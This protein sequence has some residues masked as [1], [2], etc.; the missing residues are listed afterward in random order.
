M[1][2]KVLL[3]EDA[4]SLCRILKKYLLQ[5]GFAVITADN[6]SEA[7]I[8]AKQAKPD[9][10]ISDA[11]IPYLDGPGLCHILKKDKET[12]HIP[13]IIIS[14]VMVDSS[15][16]VTG[17]EGGADDY[18]LKPFPMA[19]LLARIHAVLR[20]YDPLG[21]MTYKCR[22][23]IIELDPQAR[24]VRRLGKVVNLTRKEFD[25]L[26]LLVERAGKV[27]KPTYILETVWGYNLEDYN[28]PHTVETHISRLR[29]KLGSKLGACI[30]NVQGIGYKMEKSSP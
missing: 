19:V 10:I 30:R 16:V 5:Q 1:P 27:L 4:L 13:I 24:E 15:N 20:R 18:L 3:V 21:A 17:L 7:L 22:N 29:K 11:Q 28:D 25:L 9:I 2:K 6:G 23:G 8:L 26:L 14:G 12:A